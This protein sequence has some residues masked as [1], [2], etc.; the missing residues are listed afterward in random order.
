MKSTPSSA[1]SLLGRRVDEGAANNGPVINEDI[2]LALGIPWDGTKDIV[3]M[4]IA[5]R[6]RS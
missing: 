1:W 6:E 5:E 4:W 2:Y 3:G